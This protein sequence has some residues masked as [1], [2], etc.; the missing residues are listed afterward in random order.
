MVP[1]HSQLPKRALLLPP[2]ML[3]SSGMVEVLQ[4][5]QPGTWEMSFAGHWTHP[6]SID[7]NM[8]ALLSSHCCLTPS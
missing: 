7:Q 6:F 1:F 2:D 8:M 5:T 4:W 3:R